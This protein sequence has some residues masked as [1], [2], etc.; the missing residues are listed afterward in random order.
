MG[1]G[2]E[3]HAR[4]VSLT[5]TR[6]EGSCL[7]ANSVQLCNLGKHAHPARCSRKAYG[8]SS[9][10]G[11]WLRNRVQALASSACGDVTRSCFISPGIPQMIPSKYGRGQQS[12]EARE[13]WHAHASRGAEPRKDI[14]PAPV[15]DLYHNP[16]AQGYVRAAA[17]GHIC[18]RQSKNRPRG[19]AKAYH[20]GTVRSLSPKGFDT[21]TP[22]AKA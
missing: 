3:M 15:G 8:T 1:W 5:C 6:L 11:I 19:G 12:I 4:Q 10:D 22:D 2:G 18:Q 21:L 14:E 16:S 9:K 20:F 13:S 17:P 7:H